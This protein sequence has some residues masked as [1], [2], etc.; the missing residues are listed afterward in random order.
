MNQTI[1]ARICLCL[2][3]GFAI[4]LP[5]SY[6]YRGI[7]GKIRRALCKKIF[8]KTGKSFNIEKGAKFGNG[9]LVEIGDYSGIG[10]NCTVPNN[11]VIGNYVMMGP[12]CYILDSNHQFKDTS[13]PMMFQGYTQK[14]KTIIEDD[15]WLGVNVTMTAGRHLCKGTIV[16]AGSIV[17]KDFPEYSIIGGNPAKLLR[18][19]KN[20]G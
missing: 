16:G 7:P 20:N 18:L 2:Y 12:N 17:T 14:K 9:R 6:K 8:Y 19:R 1:T 11:I 15:V 5:Q 10:I 4:Y 13:I 3:Y